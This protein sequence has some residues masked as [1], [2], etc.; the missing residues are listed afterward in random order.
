MPPKKLA[1]IV[2]QLNNEKEYY[3][4]IS[5]QNTKIDFLDLHLD[6]CGPCKAVETNYRM[7]LLLLD[8]CVNNVEFFSIGEKEMP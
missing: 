1:E 8:N 4:A 7:L 3:E 6:W 5:D 2:C